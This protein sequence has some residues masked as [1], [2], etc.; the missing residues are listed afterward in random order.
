[1]D[2]KIKKCM[3]CEK[4]DEGD[5]VPNKNCCKLCQKQYKH[6]WYEKNKVKILKR[7]K[8]YAST[9][10]EKISAYYQKWRT[11][12]AEYKKMKD[13]EYYGNHKEK[14]LRNVALYAL[15]H[16]VEI[17]E[18]KKKYYHT[19]KDNPEFRARISYYSH[20]RRQRIAET[21][22]G[23]VLSWHMEQMKKPTYI[24]TYCRK[25]YPSI[26]EIHNHKM[27]IDHIIPLVLGGMHTI[28]NVCIS[29]HSCNSAKN[30]KTIEEWDKYRVEKLGH[31]LPE[32]S[33]DEV[34]HTQSSCF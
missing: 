27:S 6:E 5:F 32:K 14:I 26:T 2:N 9:R 15:N 31:V 22:D 17:L 18:Y 11:E 29:C 28:D 3:Y 1:M 4:D 16:P 34:G 23:L 30:A 21:D 19:N 7:V 33:P 25:E 24:C 10:K 20:I 13:Q 8:K 12:N